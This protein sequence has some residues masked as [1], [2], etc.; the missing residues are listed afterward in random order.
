M[1][2]NGNRGFTLIELL[3]VVAIIGILAA[4]AIPNLLSAMQRAKQKR[5]MADM[6]SIATAWEARFV[7]ENTYIAA[8]L[9]GTVN[10]PAAEVLSW[11]DMTAMLSPTYLRDV[12]AKDSWGSELEFRGDAANWWIRSAGK[13]RTFDGTAYTVL[14]TH[15]FACDIVYSDGTF[16]VYPEGLQ[17][18]TK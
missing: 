9:A 13:D 16:V 2:R 7:D 17:L 1:N 12:P 15:D 6:R 3:I 18:S 11:V 8:G 5:T 4:I 14:S 10:W